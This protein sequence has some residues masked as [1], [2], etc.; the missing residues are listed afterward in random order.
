MC[1]L[2]EKK[3]GFSSSSWGGSRPYRAVAREARVAYE[4]RGSKATL[5]SLSFSLPPPLLYH[6]VYQWEGKRAGQYSVVT[7]CSFGKAPVPEQKSFTTKKKPL[8]N[9][10]KCDSTTLKII[11]E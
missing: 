6:F 5:L 11:N 4:A 1:V 9:E 7:Y 3:V 8:Y 10:F 2:P